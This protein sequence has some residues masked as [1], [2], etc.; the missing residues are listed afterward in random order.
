MLMKNCARKKGHRDCGETSFSR[1]VAIASSVAFEAPSFAQ[2]LAGAPNPLAGQQIFCSHKSGQAATR[3]PPSLTIGFSWPVCIRNQSCEAHGLRKGNSRLSHRWDRPR[4]LRESLPRA[5]G[6]NWERACTG[7][8]ADQPK[9]PYRG[10][11]PARLEGSRRSCR[12]FE[13][14]FFPRRACV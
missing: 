9:Y 10:W 8:E 7:A 14:V 3:R 4:Y 12:L 11:W 6:T 2:E 1:A 13:T 5:A